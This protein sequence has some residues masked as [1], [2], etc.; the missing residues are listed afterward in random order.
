[1]FC[2]AAAVRF[3]PGSSNVVRSSAF[4]LTVRRRCMREGSIRLL[5][6]SLVR[7]LEEEMI[8]PAMV[9]QAELAAAADRI[10]MQR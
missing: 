4:I 6:R 9:L 7:A 10:L 5:L 8:G 1:M 2:G 3:S